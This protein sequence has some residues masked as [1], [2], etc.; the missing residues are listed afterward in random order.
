MRK[1]IKYEMINAYEWERT[2]EKSMVQR[3]IY[4][5]ANNKKASDFQS[6]VYD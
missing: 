2:R 1:A 5:D 6:S 4:S 3:A